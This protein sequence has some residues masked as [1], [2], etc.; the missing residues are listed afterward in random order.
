MYVVL[1]ACCFLERVAGWERCGLPH[2]WKFCSLLFLCN[3][4]C[5]NTLV[6]SPLWQTVNVDFKFVGSRHCILMQPSLERV[7]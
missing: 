5:F 3:I 4:Y 1:D 2:S 7:A 6:A